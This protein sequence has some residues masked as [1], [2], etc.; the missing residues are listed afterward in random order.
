[1]GGGED[2]GDAFVLAFAF[3]VHGELVGPFGL[4]FV[5]SGFHVPAREVTAIGPGKCARPEAADGSALPIAVIDMGSIQRGLFCSGIGERR[6]DGTLP[7]GFGNV[8]IGASD[9]C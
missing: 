9:V 4:I 8:V 6:A 5:D 3:L 1:M 7:G 2:F